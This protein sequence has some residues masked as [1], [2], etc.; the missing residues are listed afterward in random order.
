MGPLH[1]HLLTLSLSVS[2]SARWDGM[3]WDHV[4]DM[5]RLS[6]FVLF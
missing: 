4:D 6:S 2:V 3:G 5:I 1:L